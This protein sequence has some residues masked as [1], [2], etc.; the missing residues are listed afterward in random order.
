MDKTAIP[1]PTL[2]ALA[3]KMQS[4]GLNSLALDGKHW[5]VRLT[6]AATP[7][8]PAPAPATVPAAEIFPITQ[9]IGAPMPGTLLRRHPHSQQDFVAPGQQIV[10]G[11]V[12]ALVQVGPLYVPVISPD[13]GTVQS[14]A[15][16][17]SSAVEYD[18]D[19]LTFRSP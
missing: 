6:F 15:A 12:V 3:R 8:A 10:A 9:R 18:E 19:V 7:A 17:H 4:S 5:S 2:R 14:F 13:N 11:E 1:L 16:E